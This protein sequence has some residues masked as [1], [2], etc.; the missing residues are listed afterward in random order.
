[1]GKQGTNGSQS[2]RI[3]RDNPEEW[4][5]RKVQEFIQSL[6]EEEVTELLGRR[7]SERRQA[8]SRSGP[9]GL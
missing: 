7:K 2:L 4:V 5:R 3:V 6:L 9:G 8:S 1:M